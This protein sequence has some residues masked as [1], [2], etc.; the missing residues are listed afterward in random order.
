[1]SVQ[2]SLPCHITPKQMIE[3]SDLIERRTGI[4]IYSQMRET[5][6]ELLTL[7][8]KT[9]IPRYIEQL[10][11][12]RV[13]DDIW[14]TLVN[15]LTIGETYF[16]RDRSHFHLLRTRILPDLIKAR[17]RNNNLHLSIWSIGC[18]TGEEPYSLAITLDELLPD[19]QNWRINLVGSD[20]NARSL[21][22]ARLAIYR[23][24]AFR[25][26][27][28]DF[29]G[30]Y[31]D[32]TPDG[33]LLKPHIQKMV[34]FRHENI[35]DK[36]SGLPHVDVILCRNVLLYF[37]H[38]HTHNAEELI[39][40]SLIPGG[41][42]LLGHAENIQYDPKRWITH[43]YPRTLAFQRPERQHLNSDGN[44]HIHTRQTQVVPAVGHKAPTNLYDDSIR[45][46]QKEN[47]DHAETLL[48]QLLA[49]H[50]DHASAHTLKAYVLANRHE[51]EQSRD[52]INIALE[53]DPLLADAY[54]L[55][56]MLQLENDDPISASET[57][58]SAL[59]C[60]RNHPLASFMLGNLHA[61]SGQFI[62]ANSYWENSKRAI[63]MLTPDSPVS[64]ISNISVHQLNNMVDEQLMGW[65]N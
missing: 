30:H 48:D 61:Q 63:M 14:Q 20:I 41:W 7:L 24:W 53:I 45:A 32:P 56:A 38:T 11:H 34:R 62:K 27:D 25:H 42:L 64:D 58:R 6:S 8:E 23:K 50:P 57:L 17:R 36:Q 39:F 9:N 40:N 52:E 1:M 13:T 31:F 10:T 35:L 26:T 19:I 44:L 21:H 49:A 51:F 47:Y 54:Y 18:A 46:L 15:A 43:I 60:Q 65:T 29:Q 12:A 33:L 22:T 5:L 2:F 3:I 37:T 55:R 28:L 59:Y 16:L 4:T